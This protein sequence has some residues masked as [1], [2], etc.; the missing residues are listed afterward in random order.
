MKT[1]DLISFK[2]IDFGN[3][4]WSNPCIV[5][6][7]YDSPNEGLWSVWCDGIFCVIG[8][9]NYEILYLTSSVREVLNEAG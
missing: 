1:G 2:P 9:T 5:M 3:E 8:D 4:D 6:S 7:Q